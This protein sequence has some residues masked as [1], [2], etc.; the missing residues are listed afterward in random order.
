M[1]SFSFGSHCLPIPGA[2]TEAT[3]NPGQ[4]GTRN[5]SNEYV[6]PSSKKPTVFRSEGLLSDVVYHRTQDYIIFGVSLENMEEIFT[7]S[8]RKYKC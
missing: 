6:A 5:K 3:P 2:I 4:G 7:L 8:N 1:F